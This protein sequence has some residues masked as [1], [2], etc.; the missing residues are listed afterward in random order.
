MA[1][2]QKL[3]DDEYYRDAMLMACGCFLGLR[4]SDI[5]PL[6]W[7]DLTQEDGMVKVVEKKTG[8][9]R[10]M[11]INPKLSDITNE[12][13]E[14][15][16]IKY[17]DGY[18]FTGQIY[19]QNRPITTT[20][21][22]QILKDIQKRY[23]VRSAKV[24]STHTLRKTFGR[25]VWLQQCELGRGEQALQLL[26]EVFGHEHTY[27]TKRYLGIRQEEILSVYNILTDK[28]A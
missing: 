13:L 27:V 4:I 24:F 17:K 8:K 28:N 2:I 5:L 14:S 11:R 6:K 20:R 9:T 10:S 15:M 21:A 3:I 26:A 12:C 25:R 16:H 22:Y 1:T 19:K 23:D 18:I 7:K